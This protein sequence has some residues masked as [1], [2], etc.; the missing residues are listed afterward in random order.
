MIDVWEEFG[1]KTLSPSQ[2]TKWAQDRGQWYASARA[3]IYDDAGPAAWRGDAVESGL[4]AHLMGKGAPGQ[5]A[6]QTFEARSLEWSNKHDGEVHPKADEEEAV[7]EVT[8]SRAIDAWEKCGFGKLK[9]YQARA[10]TF[11]PGTRVKMFGKPDFALDGWCVDLKTA[12]QLP[13][14]PKDD[15]KKPEAK[16][17]HAIAASFYAFARNESRAGIL[18]VSTAGNP[19]DTFRLIEL[20]AN[21]I[22]FFVKAAA[23]IVR[24]IE[25][26][27]KAAIAMSEFELVSPEDAL[28]ELCRP[29]LLAQGGGLFPIW[30]GEYADRALAAVKSWN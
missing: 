12:N 4:Y 28:A 5:T 3:K 1:I 16:I 7:I 6:A 29:N 2:L 11:L 25:A 8:L 27:L 24:Q 18:Y 21:E 22:A 20:D 15:A 26:T 14:V 13:S 17:E 9:T 19:R 23:D 30:K 10:E